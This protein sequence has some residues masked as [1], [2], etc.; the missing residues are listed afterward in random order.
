MPVK[1]NG[2]AEPQGGIVYILKP[3]FNKVLMPVG[4]VNVHAL[5]FELHKVK[6][7]IIAKIIAVAADYMEVFIGKQRHDLFDIAHNVPQKE[8]LARLG[9]AIQHPLNKRG[10][11]KVH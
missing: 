11:A 3:G 2:G 7:R 4:K 8:N 6:K 5:G 10:S 9:L 1:R